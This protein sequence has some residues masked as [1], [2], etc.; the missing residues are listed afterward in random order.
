MR[1]NEPE[2]FRSLLIQKQLDDDADQH[3]GAGGAPIRRQGKG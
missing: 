2:N 1:D 3:Q